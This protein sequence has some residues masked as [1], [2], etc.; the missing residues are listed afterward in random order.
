M[1]QEMTPRQKQQRQ[2]L[3]SRYLVLK[4][5]KL[6]SLGWQNPTPQQV[7]QAARQQRYPR[8]KMQEPRLLSHSCYDNG[9]MYYLAGQIVKAMQQAG[10]PCVVF[11]HLIPMPCHLNSADI[12]PYHIGE[13]VSFGHPRLE[14]D[15]TPEYWETLDACITIVKQKYA[16]AL[17]HARG[18]RTKDPAH[19]EI[20]GWQSFAAELDPE[21]ERWHD[22]RHP[23]ETYQVPRGRLWKRFK[24]VLPKV[25]RQYERQ[26][27]GNPPSGA[28][29]D[30]A[31][32]MAR[33]SLSFLSKE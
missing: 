21:I 13:A 10:Y 29:N 12:T 6:L 7:M 33:Q 14:Y 30:I 18:V 31:G 20:I 5:R 4:K 3:V 16:V 22:N 26:H 23:T 32:E 17:E 8:E 15:V 24:E 9:P 11:E 19:V 25:A 2:N 27:A 28:A 1:S